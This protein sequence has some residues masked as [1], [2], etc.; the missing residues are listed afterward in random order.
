MCGAH[1]DSWQAS[2]TI[3]DWPA[4]REHEAMEGEPSLLHDTKVLGRTTPVSTQIGPILLCSW[5]LPLPIWEDWSFM[6]MCFFCHDLPTTPLLGP[7]SLSGSP[8]F[9]AH[10][11]SSIH[12]FSARNQQEAFK[13]YSPPIFPSAT[14]LVPTPTPLST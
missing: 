6:A 4:L 10:L 9:R 3:S 11:F 13:T 1:I 8:C 2:R 14:L 12:S 7:F 5:V